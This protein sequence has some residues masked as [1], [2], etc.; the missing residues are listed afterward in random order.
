MD[1]ERFLIKRMLGRGSFGVTYLAYDRKLRKDVALKIITLISDESP[2][3][4]L[5]HTWSS[6][7]KD[8]LDSRIQRR[9]CR[10][11][12]MGEM[13]MGKRKLKN[14]EYENAK[15]SA[16]DEIA[17]LK[18]LSNS[19]E[20]NEYIVCY[21][22]S[23]LVTE[24]ESYSNDAWSRLHQ[25]PGS[26]ISAIFI[27]SEYIDGMTLQEYIRGN[28]FFSAKVLLSIMYGLVNGLKFIHERGY[29]HGDIK[30]DNIMITKS[31]HIKYIDFGLACIQECESEDCDNSCSIPR[32]MSDTYTSPDYYR[33]SERNGAL[34]M[35]NDVWSLGVVLYQ[36]VNKGNLPFDHNIDSE[37]LR[38]NILNAP[39]YKSKNR[40]QS[41]NDYVDSFLVNNCQDR[42]CVQTQH[43]VLTNIIHS[44][45]DIITEESSP[46]PPLSPFAGKYIY[47]NDI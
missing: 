11:K 46:D 34:A 19:N 39:K 28:M 14:L 41:I 30:P 38:R 8:G 16:L 22:D 17:A 10:V 1:R 18:T 27:V 40:Y 36:L 45:Q 4:K 25:E 35:C 15:K 26:K 31:G 7:K 37:I 33:S 2:Q 9:T 43:S 6:K 20:C 32:T 3:E 47:D 24:V 44:N 21:Y 42:P 5:H 12:F 13:V 29:A 23:F